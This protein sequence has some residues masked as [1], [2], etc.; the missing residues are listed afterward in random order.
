MVVLKEMYYKPEKIFDKSVQK[1]GLCKNGK[2][3]ILKNAD[4]E[5]YC[6][7]CGEVFDV[8]M[9]AQNDSKQRTLESTGNQRN[10]PD[11]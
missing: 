6:V 4:G 9:I 1:L 10:E 7:I 11:F 2:K 5:N 3:H 8:D